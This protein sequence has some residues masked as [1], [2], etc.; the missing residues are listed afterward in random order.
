MILVFIDETADVKFKEYL[1]F[2]ITTINA[3]FYPPIKEKAQSILRTVG[4]DPEIE[5]KGS[6]LFSGSSGCTDVDIEKR[7]D[8]AHQ[9][10][11]LNIA[12]KNRRMAFY[13]GRMKSSNHREDYI[14]G[15][16]GLLY[17]VLP[18]AQ[19]GPGKNL[20]SIHCDRRDDITSAE[21]HRHIAPAAE[22]KGYVLLETVARIDSC[23][24]TVGVM[25]ADLVGYI[26][27]RIDVISNDVELFEGLTQEQL[28]NNGKIR[29]LKSSKE[30]IL[31]IKQLS[32][33]TKEV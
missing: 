22:K 1:G 19:R 2:C 3:R 24:D 15:V 27:G 18:T 31:K 5:F 16:P 10:L 12:H 21:L 23:F 14:K 32:F 29:K 11:D 7:I 8:A 33:F 4:W 9:L 6:Y 28:E 13:F 17:K 26:A 20:I 30:L 25:F